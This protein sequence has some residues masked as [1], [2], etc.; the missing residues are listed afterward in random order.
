MFTIS[1]VHFFNDTSAK[2]SI[3]SKT[4]QPARTYHSVWAGKIMV[5]NYYLKFCMSFIMCKYQSN[6][7]LN[8]LNLSVPL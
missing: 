7:A 6:N 3:N 5:Y 8:M 2:L 1:F 4:N